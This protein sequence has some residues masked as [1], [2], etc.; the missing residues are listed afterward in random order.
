MSNSLIWPIDKT[1]SD[2]TTMGQNGPGSIDNEGVLHIPLS[3][4]ITRASSSDCL[5]SYPEHWLGESYSSAEM[6]S[7]YPMAQADW[8]YTIEEEVI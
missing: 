3:S 6:Q 2:A 1:Q 8:T 7:V 5:V 4:S